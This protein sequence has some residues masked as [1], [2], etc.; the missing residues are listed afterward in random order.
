MRKRVL[1]IRIEEEIK[2]RLDSLAKQ[3]DRTTS[4]LVR[5][6]IIRGL[7]EDWLGNSAIKSKKTRAPKSER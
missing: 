7:E 1:T 4:N 5:K 6:M 3:E 2:T